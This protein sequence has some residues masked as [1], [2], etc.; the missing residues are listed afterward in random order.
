MRLIVRPTS[1]FFF[2]SLDMG[3]SKDIA[4]PLGAEIP[5]SRLEGRGSERE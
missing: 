4:D 1:D 2:L 5:T 3:L